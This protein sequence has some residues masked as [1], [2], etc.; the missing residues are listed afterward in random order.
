M[1]RRPRQTARPSAHVSQLTPHRPGRGF[2][3][4]N[5][6][7]P[8]P[9][10]HILAH[11]APCGMNTSSI[12]RWKKIARARRSV[13]TY[14]RVTKTLAL[15]RTRY[16]VRCRSCTFEPYGICQP[17]VVEIVNIWTREPHRFKARR[18]TAA[19]ED[20]VSLEI[21]LVGG[22]VEHHSELPVEN[23]E[24]ELR[25]SHVPWALRRV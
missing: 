9:T 15:C 25:C 8:M 10:A 19:Q 20:G 23:D 4:P 14:H 18:E 2:M 7:C 6:C 17:E 13:Q 1:C 24:A 3:L 5:T 12:A 22:T 11:L 21:T 16:P